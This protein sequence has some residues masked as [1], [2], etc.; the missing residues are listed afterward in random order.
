MFSPALIIGFGGF[1]LYV[2]LDISL[3]RLANGSA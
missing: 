1:F 3:N 2:V